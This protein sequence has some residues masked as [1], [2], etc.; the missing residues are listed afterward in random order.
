MV[1]LAILLPSTLNNSS[2]H[3]GCNTVKPLESFSC[4]NVDLLKIIQRETID[5]AMLK[6]CH[7]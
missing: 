2:N 1:G 6:T 7:S 5:L 4:K 3:C